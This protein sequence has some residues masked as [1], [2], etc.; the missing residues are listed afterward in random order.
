MASLSLLQD[1]LRLPDEA[2][3]V[4]EAAVVTTSEN[5]DPHNRRILAIVS[6]KEDWD[7]TEEGW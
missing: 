2:K 3:V 6:H 4:L 5:Q 7:L 1:L